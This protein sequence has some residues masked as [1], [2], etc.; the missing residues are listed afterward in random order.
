MMLDFT[1]QHVVVTGG[2]RGLGAA[3]TRAF[4]GRGAY[5]TATYVSGAEKAAAFAASVASDKLTLSCFDV[6]DYA[7]VEKFWGGLTR[8]VEVLVNNAGIRKDS[9]VGMMPAD[10][11]KKVLSINLDGTFYMSK[12]AVMAMS[13]KKYGRIINVTSPAADIGMKG[14]ASYAASKAGQGALA[15]TLAVEVASRKITVNN[16]EPGYTDTELLADISDEM[17]SEWKKQIPLGRFATVEEVAHA[18]LFLA[19]REAAYVTGT[20]LRVAGG[21]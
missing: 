11:W 10:D 6:S 7:A 15:R 3:F 8:P 14:A 20:T 17:K 19:S 2:T 13:R 21:L 16:L 1:D 4:L 5:V 18:C 12:M 9:I